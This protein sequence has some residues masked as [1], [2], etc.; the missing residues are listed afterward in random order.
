MPSTKKK[1]NK[2]RKVIDTTARD[3]EC[4]ICLED[5]KDKSY[6][7]CE[8]KHAVCNECVRPLLMPCLPSL[9]GN[10]DCCGVSWKCPLC[11]GICGF[12]NGIMLLKVLCSDDEYNRC[13][14]TA[15]KEDEE[16]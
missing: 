5:L 12:P 11:R 10:C 8:R 9:K 7:C 6:Y 4:S 2:N 16:D 13:W 1:G 3:N 14:E 15:K